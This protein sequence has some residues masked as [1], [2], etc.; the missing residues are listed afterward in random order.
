[1][2]DGSA[3]LLTSKLLISSAVLSRAW[4]DHADLTLTKHEGI[5]FA[6]QCLVAPPYQKTPSATGQTAL[7]L[8]SMKE[9]RGLSEGPAPTLLGYPSSPLFGDLALG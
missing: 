1:M 9:Q 5:G 4:D 6:G 3:L 2:C 8:P 7:E